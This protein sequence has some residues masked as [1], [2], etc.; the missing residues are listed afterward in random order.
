MQQSL[1]D[2]NTHYSSIEYDE[3]PTINFQTLVEHPHLPEIYYYIF[4]H[5]FSKEENASSQHIG[6]GVRQL[7]SIQLSITEY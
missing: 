6:S 3:A 5:T 4:Y 7:S 1:E 2:L